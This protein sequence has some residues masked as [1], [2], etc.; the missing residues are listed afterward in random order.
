MS[1]S[2]PLGL[3]AEPTTLVQL[4]RWRCE[5]QPQ[6]N[7]YTFL[8]D[9][10]GAET[11]CSYSSLDRQ[12]RA[13]AALL[14]DTLPRGEPVLLLY[15]PGLEYIAAFFGCLYAGM[16]AVP[17]FPPP[18]SRPALRLQAILHDSRATVVLTTAR[19]LADSPALMRHTPGLS[20]LRWFS[21][22]DLPAGAENGW[23]A[24]PIGAEGLAFLQYTSGST[25]T[26]KGVMLSHRNLLHNLS[27]IYRLYGMSADSRGV[28]WLVPYHDMGLIGGILAPLYGGFPVTLMPPIAFLQKPLRWLK[29]ISRYR[30]TISGGP[31]FAYQLSLSKISAQEREVL[32]LSNWQV[33]F[34]GAEPLREET[35]RRF[36][37][38]F[39]PC[40]FRYEAFYPCYGLA[41]AT[42]MVSGGEP[43]AAPVVQAVQG[44][45]FSQHRIVPTAVDEA[46]RHL[47][48]GSG[49]AVLGQRD[50]IEQL[51]PS[52]DIV[53]EERVIVQE[54]RCHT[55]NIDSQAMMQAIRPA[56]TEQH[57][58]CL[59]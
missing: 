43:T 18:L 24:P 34:N 51:T 19:L 55:R 6:G 2:V 36:A 30:A 14:Q 15:P 26:S 17:I 23:Q 7:P 12:A 35:M 4:L 47:L 9:G 37:A 25:G 52:I 20:S 53:G 31:N 39:A 48:V 41:E 59:A 50:A 13:I 1:N 22:D 38:A 27:V 28:I 16:V 46:G 21:T 3:R 57:G 8:A 45:T 44:A 49:R 32:D 10:E 42:L 5:C 40:G 54:V 58:L 33:A 11:H 56:V 29:A